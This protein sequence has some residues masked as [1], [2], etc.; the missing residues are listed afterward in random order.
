MESKTNIKST[1]NIKDIQVTEKK[2]IP[3]KTKRSIKNIGG[4]GDSKEKFPKKKGNI[5]N[6]KQNLISWIK[7][8]LPIIFF[9]IIGGIIYIIIYLFKHKKKGEL[10]DLIF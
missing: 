2:I 7:I 6:K 1:N 3:S 8:L 9:L 5:K 10:V 4:V